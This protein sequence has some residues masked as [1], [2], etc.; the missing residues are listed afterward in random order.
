MRKQHTT[1]GRESRKKPN[2]ME[3]NMH[4]NG[5]CIRTNNKRRSKRFNDV[6]SSGFFYLVF[7]LWIRF[8][9]CSFESRVV[10]IKSDDDGKQNMTNA[11]H[12]FV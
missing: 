12:K 2:G 3:Y 5:F 4:L 9:F 11:E 1:E 10:Y 8:G 7:D 6:Y